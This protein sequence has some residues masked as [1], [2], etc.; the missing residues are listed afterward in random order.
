MW[1]KLRSMIA[2]FAVFAGL[3]LA[4]SGSLAG[5]LTIPSSVKT[6]EAE[7]FC[8]DKSIS[9][10]ELPDGILRIESKAFANSSIDS[11]NLPASLTF[12]AE[13]AFDQTAIETVTA[14][15][16]TYAYQWAVLHGLINGQTDAE[17][18]EYTVEEDGV[19]ITSYNGNASR[20]LVP[21]ELEGKPVVSVQLNP[22]KPRNYGI[23]K[24]VLPAQPIAIGENAFMNLPNLS[25]IEGL[26]YVTSVGRWAFFDAAVR[27]LVFS[28]NLHHLDSEAFNASII[29]EITI[30]SDLQYEDSAFAAYYMKK[31]NLIKG[32]GA[33]TITLIDGVLFS[34]DKKTL[35]YYPAKKAGASYAIPDGTV[36]IAPEA[37][38]TGDPLAEIIFPD[39]VTDIAYDAIKQATEPTELLVNRKS[40]AYTYAS[41]LASRDSLIRCV[42]INSDEET[43]QQFVTRIVRE[44]ASSGSTYEKALAL[45]DWLIDYAEYD[46]R[47]SGVAI[48]SGAGML[49]EGR[50]VC[51]A[52][53]SAYQMLLTEAGIECKPAGNAIH[54]FVAVKV[55]SDW[56]YVDCTWDDVSSDEKA[57]HTYFGFEDTIRYA[58]YG[59]DDPDTLDDIIIDPST[60]NVK[61][62]KNH[63]WYKKGYCTS[64]IK[65]AKNDVKKQ[66]DAGQ[67]TFSVSCQEENIIGMLTAAA[68]ADADWTVGGAVRKIACS[69]SDGV[70]HCALLDDDDPSLDNYEYDIRN[71]QIRILK[72]TGSSSSV[73]IPSSIN[74][75][76]VAYIGPAFLGNTTV[77]TVKLPDT[78]VEIE[79][80]AFRGAALL[81]K[82]NFPDHL[83]V[84]GD[85]AFS[86]CTNLSSDV[87]LPSGFTSIGMLAFNHCT[88]IKSVSLPSTT[89]LS[90]MA[91]ID[92]TE[93]TEL[94]LAEGITS[95]PSSAFSGCTS[96]KAVSFPKSLTYL[97]SNAFFRTSITKVSIPENVSLIGVAPFQECNSLTS[98]TVNSNNPYYKSADNIVFSKDG[99]TILFS[100]IYAGKANY[101]IPDGVTTLYERAFCGN[102]VIKN[103]TIPGSVTEIP[104]ELFTGQFS[105]NKTALESLT[106]Q[107]GVKTLGNACFS[108]CVHLSEVS[109][110]NSV[111]SMGYG[112]FFGT[113]VKELRIPKKVTTIPA[114]FFDPGTEKLYIHE[115]VTKAEPCDYSTYITTVYGK[116][117]T[118]AE[119]FAETY[120]LPFVAID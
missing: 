120:G 12:I 99:K 72:Y 81:K 10:V 6:I 89:I 16:G 15:E 100:T 119:T 9:E 58:V 8:G 80:N 20:V 95:I 85:S 42:L 11:V 29:Q 82:I 87:V 27:K 63:Y 115:N 116:A 2:G 78:I 53:A 76:P 5:M 93:I 84:I 98:L 107:N 51:A 77:T 19:Y 1:S 79:G 31:I 40:A 74:G 70:L 43:L 33:P 62:Y 97:G 109:L 90:D 30:P 66:L 103:L 55:G 35:L 61:Q 47:E 112:V 113:A 14:E 117:G 44:K 92:C 114:N 28:G 88:S 45:H 108:G 24:V 59:A 102:Q 38:I 26:E 18:W 60:L 110:P 13:D 86:F 22:E 21:S 4:A 67:K 111:T 64:A 83:S 39:S 56:M 54:V 91:F 46:F 17:A 52:Y 73:T 57:N 49:R 34:A 105:E 104:T 37:F 23:T 41:Q 75:L 48:A 3:I 96:L 118:F 69:W 101:T 71:N 50:G 106:I 7:A 36:R 25:E 32:S 68:V 94:T 65:T